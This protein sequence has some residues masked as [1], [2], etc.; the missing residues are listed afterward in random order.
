MKR[1]ILIALLS[2]L[3][4]TT[5][6]AALIT[7]QTSTTTG[8]LDSGVHQ[9]TYSLDLDSNPSYT[10][11][12]EISSATLKFNFIDDAD[13]KYLVSDSYSGY[14]YRYENTNGTAVFARDRIK[15]Y[16]EDSE[17]VELD[18][19]N[20]VSFDT[21]GCSFS[22]Y[23]DN[24]TTFDGSF[25]QY[26]DPHNDNQYHTPTQGPHHDFALNNTYTYSYFYEQVVNS[27][28]LTYTLSGT[29]L[30]TLAT[31]GSI[32]FNLNVTGDLILQQSYL[33]VQVTQNPV[34]AQA[35][36]AVPEPTMLWLMGLGV[37]GL[38]RFSRKK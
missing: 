33:D 8:Y 19:S 9:Y 37:V 11:P 17:Q 35:S 4:S 29:E 25:S 13:N 24:G 6:N 30:L 1:N 32:D 34:S 12:Y 18:S 23:S 16:Q 26:H 21:D 5:A 7:T 36:N 22:S 20:P 15:K 2:L 14:S 10:Q 38:T 28:A 3:I 31:T 27:F